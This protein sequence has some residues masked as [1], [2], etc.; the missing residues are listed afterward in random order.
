MTRVYLVRH[1]KA[2]NRLRW[3][4]PDHL[5]PLTKQ[6]RRQAEALQALFGEESFSRLASSPYVR[7]VQTLEPLA[8]AEGLPIEHAGELSEGAPARGAL[9]LVRS[10]ASH[11]PAVACTHGDVLLDAV[12][13]LRSLGVPLEGPLAARKGATW[14]LE[15]DGRDI[16]SGT[17][18]DAPDAATSR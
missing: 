9:E 7:C 14:V 12:V 3:T 18:L 15:V 4:E 10:L 11:G 8:E 6:G 17:Y 16:R 1:A 13:E 5:R 2:K